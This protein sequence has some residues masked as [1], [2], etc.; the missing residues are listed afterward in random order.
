MSGS[1]SSPG[2]IYDATGT[3]IVAGAQMAGVTG[4]VV[5]CDADGNLSLQPLAGGSASPSAV[6]T[7]RVFSV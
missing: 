5:T 7:Q 1:V 2:D 6:I 3:L 4:D